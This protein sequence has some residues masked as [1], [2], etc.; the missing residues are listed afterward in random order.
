M[1]FINNINT[2]SRN[3]GKLL[4]RSWFFRVYAI[5]LLLF[6]VFFSTMYFAI[7]S[8]A[9]WSHKA[10]ESVITSYSIH[11][12]KLYELFFATKMVQQF[13]S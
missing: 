2:I 10:L 7:P 9:R 4:W 1:S 6:L 8:Q 13:G 11:Y 5:L 3:E 12:T